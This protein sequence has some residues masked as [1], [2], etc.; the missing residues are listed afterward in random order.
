MKKFIYKITNRLNGKIYIGQTTNPTRRFQEHRACGYGQETEKILYK[1]F[2]K[3]GIGNFSF[4]VIEETEDYNEREKYWIKYYNCLV[5]NGYNM[6]EGGKI[7]QFFMEKN[8]LIVLIL[9]K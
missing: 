1:A 8:T 4:E 2:S 5:P 6:N 3:Y 7:L 9:K